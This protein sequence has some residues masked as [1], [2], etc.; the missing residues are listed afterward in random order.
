MNIKAILLIAVLP[1]ILA[2]IA[3]RHLNWFTYTK[4]R[5]YR[6]NKLEKFAKKMESTKK[7]DKGK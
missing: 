7:L 2:L 4:N 6:G 3:Y 1:L 5:K